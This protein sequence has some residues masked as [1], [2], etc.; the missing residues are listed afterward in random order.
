MPPATP[1]IRGQPSEITPIKI[2]R[3]ISI[4]YARNEAPITERHTPPC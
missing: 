2:A 4:L 1:S 3:A